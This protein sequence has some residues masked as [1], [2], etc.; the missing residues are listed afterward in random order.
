MVT[1][2]LPG[3]LPWLAGLLSLYLLAPLLAGAQQ[4]V[5][6]DWSSVDAGALLGACG[7]SI[8]SAGVATLLIALGGV[9]LGYV[10][11]RRP[12]R[13]VAALG[14]VVQLPLALPPLSSGVLLLFLLG[15]A[16]PLGRVLNG[17]LTDSFAGIV[18]AE[19]FVAAP[20]LI[21]AARS[22]F[23]AVDPVLE[24]VAATLG[25]RPLDVFLRV[26]LPIAWPA[27]LSGLLLTWLRAFGEFGATVMVA[28]HPYSLPVYTYVAFGAQGLPAMLPVVLPTLGFALVVMALSQFA[29]GP[30][31]R[32][33]VWR[34]RW[35]RS[36]EPRAAAVAA[37]VTDRRGDGAEVSF[38]FEKQLG[39]FCLDVAWS[40]GARRLA[41]LGPSGSGKS[42]TL[43][44]IAGI[45]VCGGG[46]VMVNG[47]ELSRVEPA[48]R[49]IAY[50]PQN[51]GLFPHLTLR[52]QLQFPPG[53][54]P[55]VAAVWVQRLGLRGLEERRPAELSLGQQQRVALA[56]ALTR[57][58]GLLLLDEPF[59]ALDAPLRARLRRELHAL[60]GELGATTILVTHDPLE[61]AFLADEVLVLAE[62]RVL[63]S[64]AV[65]AVFRRPANETVARLVGADNVATGVVAD[66]RHIAIGGGVLVATAGPDLTPGAHVGWSFSPSRAR[67]TADGPYWGRVEGVASMGVGRQVTI[68]AGD[69]RVRV[70]DGRSDAP[71]G[72]SCGFEIDPHSVQVWPLEEAGVVERDVSVP[73]QRPGPLN[74]F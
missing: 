58:G 24:G 72:E 23:A 55:A 57:H 8:A 35:P 11:A 41:I 32:R 36:P 4:V 64:G 53:A 56:R 62:G 19:V 7:V 21:I 16:S 71:L 25:R 12:G 69:A 43:K 34:A 40:P 26:S 37:G 59:S 46:S 68:R 42:L 65:G 45:E 50:V 2:R 51:Y 49:D 73:C 54:D 15:Y 22:G 70:F 60:Q 28:Y 61:A 14:F 63:Q 29:A 52:Q 10:L 9:P 13:A 27:I 74:F 33:R 17:A 18:A 48:A 6:A 38:R 66:A 20:F 39:A 3:P 31:R 67:I 1:R 47:R 30:R 44:L 5:L